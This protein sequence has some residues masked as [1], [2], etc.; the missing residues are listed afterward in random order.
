MISDESKVCLLQFWFDKYVVWKIRMLLVQVNLCQKLLFLYQLTHNMTTDCSWNYH[1][2]YK[3]RTWACSFHGNYMNNLL[4]YWGLVD[5]RIIASEKDLSVNWIILLRFGSEFNSSIFTILATIEMLKDVWF[6]YE[7][8]SRK[9]SK[10]TETSKCHK[11]M[12]ISSQ[13]IIFELPKL[14]A[15]S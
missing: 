15:V 2:N 1:E 10:N 5:A 12:T 11:K 6:F 4:S 8:L 13:S 3:W 14:K 7:Y 9:N